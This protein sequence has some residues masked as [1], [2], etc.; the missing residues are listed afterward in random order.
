[1]SDDGIAFRMDRAQLSPDILD[2]GVHSSIQARLG[3]LPYEIHQLIP[4]IHVP[5]TPNEGLENLVFITGKIQRFAMVRDLTS[6]IIHVKYLIW[7]GVA[8]R[9]RMRRSTAFTLAESSLGL[10]GLVV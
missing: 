2:V 7:C 6:G 4:G 5:R 3:L 1:M 10:N 9:G 8:A